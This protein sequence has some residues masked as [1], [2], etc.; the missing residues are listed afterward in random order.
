ME[1][2]SWAVIIGLSFLL[3][4][5]LRAREI[6]H[7]IYTAIIILLILFFYITASKVLSQNKIDLKSFEGIV[8]AIKIYFVWLVHVFKNAKTLAGNAIKMDWVGNLNV[9]KP[10]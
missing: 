7:R 3:Y 5:L 9:S 8:Y 10:F 2:I 1:L 4:L 6:K